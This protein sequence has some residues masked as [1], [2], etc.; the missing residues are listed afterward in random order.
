MNPYKPGNRKDEA[1]KVVLYRG[2]EPNMQEDEGN[3]VT[4][5]SW[6]LTRAGNHLSPQWLYLKPP[7]PGKRERSLFYT[8]EAAE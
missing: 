2:Q 8:K 3:I 4:K 5:G 6:R 7:K 1:D